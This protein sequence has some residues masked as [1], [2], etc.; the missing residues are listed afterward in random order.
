[1]KLKIPVTDRQLSRV[2]EALMRD[3]QASRATV[4]QASNGGTNEEESLQ[5]NK[6]A[7][8]GD[9]ESS[10]IRAPAD[11]SR[12]G[13][14]PRWHRPSNGGPNEEEALQQDKM[15][16]CTQNEWLEK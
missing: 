16:R 4:A 9:D 13:S 3:I 14:S 15:A 5:Q 10:Q 8:F 1:M 12:K 7:R 11:Q 6:M 2:A